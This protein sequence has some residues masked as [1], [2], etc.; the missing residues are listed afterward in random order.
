[1]E[2]KE[3]N[4]N[5]VDASQKKKKHKGITL[6]ILILIIG[7]VGYLL[8]NNREGDIKTV[9]KSSLDKIV[10]K[11]DLETANVTYNVIAKKCKDSKNC[12]INSGNMDDFEMV[13][14]C[15]GTL[16]AGIDFKE[17]KLE[18]DEK[19]KSV[20][21]IV[22]EAVIKGEPNIGSVKA[23]N[24][25]DLPANKLPEARKLCQE[26]AKE[27]SDKDNKLLPAAKEQARVVLE[28][29]YNQWVKAKNPEC[30]VIVK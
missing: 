2:E 5:E 11:S 24:G 30:K 6:L 16:T 21:V 7:G 25:E 1:M 9:I 10:E 14:S 22:P 4:I 18:V 3:N 19:S 17:V 26:T 28:E 8:I 13:L 20:T 27:K 23:L 12:N 29:Y 15:K